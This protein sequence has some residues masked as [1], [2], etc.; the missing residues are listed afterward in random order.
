MKIEE[1]LY[2]GCWGRPGH[3]L[4][5]RN[6]ALAPIRYDRHLIRY[7]I[8]TDKLLPKDSRQVEGRAVLTYVPD[9]AATILAWWDRSGDK[10]FGS[11]SMIFLP[12]AVS[13]EYVVSVAK[14]EFPFIINRIEARTRLC[15]VAVQKKT[16]IEIF[17]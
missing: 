9:I 2:L 4:F 5:R 11:S 8:D 10:R 1:P 12:G 16:E 15:L 13:P 14:T 7:D 6:G 17:R 3:F